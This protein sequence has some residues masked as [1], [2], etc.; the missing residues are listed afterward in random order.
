M[1]KLSGNKLRQL[2]L[3]IGLMFSTFLILAIL[4]INA[5]NPIPLL[6]LFCFIVGCF[7]VYLIYKALFAPTKLSSEYYYQIKGAR[8]FGEFNRSCSQYEKDI[9]EEKDLIMYKEF[10]NAFHGYFNRLASGV[11]NQPIQ[12][13]KPM[14][15]REAAYAGTMIGGVAV[16]MA[17]A[18]EAE[19][20]RKEYE[21]NALDVIKSKIEVGNAYETAERC[22]NEMVHILNKYPSAGNDWR[23]KESSIMKHL[24]KEYV[25]K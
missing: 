25:M 18:M 15:T 22:Y 4:I 6:T 17:A 8:L 21:Q 9:K 16:G 19:R 12:Y 20:K 7:G 23:D 24:N 2:E 5:P 3:I 10:E 1:Q 13:K 11:L 14:S